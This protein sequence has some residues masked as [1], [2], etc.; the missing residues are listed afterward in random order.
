MAYA[1]LDS[2]IIKLKHLWHFGVNASLN[3]ETREGKAFVNLKAE[4]G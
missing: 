1:E 4:L 3:V 2:F